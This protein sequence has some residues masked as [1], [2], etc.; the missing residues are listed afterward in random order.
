MVVRI[1]PRRIDV[2]PSQLGSSYRHQ[3]FL[4]MVSDG[5]KEAQAPKTEAVLAKK[6][7]ASQAVHQARDMPIFKETN[8][9]SLESY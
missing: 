1:R 8:F 4:K 5:D 9:L 3:Y 2:L 7:E 6:S